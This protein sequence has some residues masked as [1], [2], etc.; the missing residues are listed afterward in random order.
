MTDGKPLKL[1]LTA[2]EVARTLGISRAKTYELLT[3]GTL[4][5]IR[6]GGSV[7]VPLEK[8]RA[9]VEENTA[10]TRTD[11]TERRPGES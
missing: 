4:P 3:D 8:L 1:L 2:E 5:T 10:W 7:R 9:W 11:T 6:I